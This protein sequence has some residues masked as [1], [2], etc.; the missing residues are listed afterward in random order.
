MMAFRLSKIRQLAV[1]L[2][3]V[4][5]NSCLIGRAY[6]LEK[7]AWLPRTAGIVALLAGFYLLWRG[8]GQFIGNLRKQDQGFR[9]DL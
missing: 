6:Y 3:W 4:G 5:L 9:E 2:F 7:G 1:T 8:V